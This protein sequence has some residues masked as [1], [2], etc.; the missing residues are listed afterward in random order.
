MG[1]DASSG[2]DAYTSNESTCPS[3]DKAGNSLEDVEE[4]SDNPVGGL[5]CTYANSNGACIYFAVSASSFFPYHS[6]G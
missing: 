3:V 2:D 5:I 6:N 4:S 1:M